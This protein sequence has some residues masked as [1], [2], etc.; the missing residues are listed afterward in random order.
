MTTEL[1]RYDESGHVDYPHWPTCL[2]NC[3]AREEE[4]ERNGTMTSIEMFAEF[5]DELMDNDTKTLNRLESMLDDSDGFQAEAGPE[6]C[7]AVHAAV[8]GHRR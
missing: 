4:T 5:Y 2:I 1:V 6:F 3:P 8:K 7:K